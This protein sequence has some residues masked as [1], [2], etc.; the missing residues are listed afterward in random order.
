MFTERNQTY[1]LVKTLMTGHDP[2]SISSL[3]VENLIAKLNEPDFVNYIKSF[4]IF[5]PSRCLLVH[6]STSVHTL[7]IIA[8][9]TPRQKITQTG[10]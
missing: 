7:K 10:S 8:C 3:N 1:R 5:C 9:F 2:I 6:S 4:D